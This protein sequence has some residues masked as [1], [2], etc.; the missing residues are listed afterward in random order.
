MEKDKFDRSLKEALNR[1]QPTPPVDMTERFVERLRKEKLPVQPSCRRR[2]YLIKWKVASVVAAAAMLL[3]IVVPWELREV[4]PVELSKQMSNG[5]LQS[6]IGEEPPVKVDS[7]TNESQQRENVLQNTYSRQPS[8]LLASAKEPPIAVKPLPQETPSE[9]LSAI[10]MPGT[11]QQPA[12]TEISSENVESRDVLAFTPSEIELME[13][14]EKMK[15]QVEMYNAEL[16]QCI[17]LEQREL[18]RQSI[19][20]EKIVEKNV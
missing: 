4:T 14:A 16:M 5:K 8:T 19:A 7:H 2:A 17:L 3:F 1:M 15:V 13:R 20:V 18:E 10:T 12:S 6:A 11:T 9:N